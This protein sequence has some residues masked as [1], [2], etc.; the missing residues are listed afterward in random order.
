MPMYMI[1][2]DLA[3]PGQKYQQIKAVIES[4]N[5]DCYW[6]FLQSGWLLRTDLDALAILNRISPYTDGND[7]LFVCKL[8]GESAWIGFGG[9]GGDWIKSNMY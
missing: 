1:S 5:P 2:Y 4:I 8:S 9:A 7:K 3:I 6:N